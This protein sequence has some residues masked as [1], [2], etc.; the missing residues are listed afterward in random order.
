MTTHHQW[1]RHST[2]GTPEAA[3]T[4]HDH[5]I[6]NTWV[7][8]RCRTNNSR[9]L[10]FCCLRPALHSG[11]SITHTTFI[12]SIGVTELVQYSTILIRTIPDTSGVYFPQAGVQ[13]R[14]KRY[15]IHIQM[16]YTVHREPKHCRFP[17]DT[18]ERT[19]MAA[20][21]ITSPRCS[22]VWSA[23][24]GDPYLR[25]RRIRSV[26]TQYNTSEYKSLCST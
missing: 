16:N 2:L 9:S 13:C 12:Q 15:V 24:I 5:V 3:E 8:D 4:A 14:G 22:L 25:T 11:G 10:I 26:Y 1:P 20:A 23:A 6:M 7:T 19:N 21:G 17:A 18:L